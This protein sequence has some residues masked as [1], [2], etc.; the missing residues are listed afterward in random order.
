[1][2]SHTICPN[3][4][5]QDSLY[6][7]VEMEIS[8]RRPVRVSGPDG[9][10]KVEYG[11]ADIDP[12]EEIVEARGI[13]CHRCEE[14]WANEDD[15]LDLGPPVEHRCTQCEWW[16]FNDFQHSLEH[17]DCSGLVWRTDKPPVEAGA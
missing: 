10:R 16:G 11:M 5:A 8:G 2:K 14:T 9:A 1:M 13:E 4:G 6:Q 12:F 3:C 15:L 17:P 7:E